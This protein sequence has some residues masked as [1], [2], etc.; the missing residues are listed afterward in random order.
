MSFIGGK[1]LTDKKTVYLAGP[2]FTHA[3]LAFNRKLRGLLLEKGFGVFLPQEDAESDKTGRARQDQECIFRE[4]VKG[5]EGSDLVVAVLDGAD[6]DSGTA[7]EVGYAYAVC[8][9][10]IGLRTDFRALSDGA[11]NLMIELAVGALAR[12]E[13]ELLELVEKFRGQPGNAQSL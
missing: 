9:P 5:I 1:D 13:E 8:K 10:V 6:V 3:E 11:V 12:N 7:W 2:L 4:C